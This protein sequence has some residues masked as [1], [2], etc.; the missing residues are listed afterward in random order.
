MAILIHSIKRVPV[1]SEFL[2]AVTM[3]ISV[4]WNVTWKIQCKMLPPS[5]GQKDEETCAFGMHLAD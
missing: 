3:K 4:L 1:I 5:S 2:L